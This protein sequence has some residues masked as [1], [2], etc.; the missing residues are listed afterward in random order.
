MRTTLKDFNRDIDILTTI[1]IITFVCIITLSV[2]H[3]ASYLQRSHLV[4][5]VQI[6]EQKVLSQQVKKDNPSSQTTIMQQ[7]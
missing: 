2:S 3:F 4:E 5:R 6:L 7:R 1:S